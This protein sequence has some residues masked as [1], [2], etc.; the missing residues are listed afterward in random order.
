MEN[1]I[2]QE[3]ANQLIISDLLRHLNKCIEALELIGNE[4][5]QSMPLTVEDAKKAIKRALKN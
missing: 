4:T 3:N 5:G 2:E 1:T